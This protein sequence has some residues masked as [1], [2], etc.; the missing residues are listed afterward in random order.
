MKLDAERHDIRRSG[1]VLDRHRRFELAMPEHRMCQARA[2]AV[3]QTIHVALFGGLNNPR[4]FTGEYA[5]RTL[6]A[7][8][9][10]DSQPAGH[11]PKT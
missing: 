7:G 10:R 11:A 6:R 1:L 9:V 2:D 3:L 8:P 5:H 4:R